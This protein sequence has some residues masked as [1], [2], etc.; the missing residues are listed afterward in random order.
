MSLPKPYYEYGGIVLYHADCRDVLPS[1]PKV[2]LVLTD[3]PYGVGIEYDAY[4]DTEANWFALMDDVIP[5][6][7]AAA[8]MVIFPSCQIKRLDWFYSRHRPDWL[9]CWHK[10]SPGHVSAI[11]FNDWEPLVVYGRTDGLSMHDYI[12]VNNDQAM[13]LYGNPCPK[14]IRWAKHWY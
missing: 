2:D 13:G 1:L 6:L 12:S 4:D 10:G 7:R 3:P 8:D 11:G 9:I 5:M 14:P